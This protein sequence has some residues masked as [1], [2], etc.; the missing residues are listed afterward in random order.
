[1]DGLDAST[2]VQTATFRIIAESAIRSS[3]RRDFGGNHYP[4]RE[5]ISLVET[6]KSGDEIDGRNNQ[7]V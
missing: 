7:F 3:G 6:D 2:I 4:L 5:G 1:M